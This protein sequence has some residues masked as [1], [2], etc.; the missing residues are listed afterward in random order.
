MVTY[1]VL[2]T[3]VLEYNRDKVKADWNPDTAIEHLW[4]RATTC[5]K[6]ADG[7]ALALSDE[8]IM[9]LLLIP[10]EKN[11]PRRHQSLAHPSSHYPNMGQFIWEAAQLPRVIYCSICAK[12]FSVRTDVAV[13]CSFFQ[14][15]NIVVRARFNLPH[16]KIFNRTTNS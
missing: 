13:Y 16:C 6:F 15:A 8:A 14:L 7:T 2:T 1:G 12:Y 11:I 5:K 4:T 3:E 9:H 10:L